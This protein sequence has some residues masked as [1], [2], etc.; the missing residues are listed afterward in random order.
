MI[1]PLRPRYAAALLAAELVVVIVLVACAT[2]AQATT[3][4]DGSHSN[5]TGPGTCSH[6]GGI[7]SGGA[8]S[9]AVDKDCTDFATQQDA[10]AYF[11]GLGGSATNNVD[12]LDADHDGIAC[13]DNP[14][15]GGLP[16]PPQ[17]PPLPPDCG[18][19]LVSGL[20][21]G[22]TVHYGSTVELTAT[23]SGPSDNVSLIISPASAYFG[24]GPLSVVGSRVLATISSAG[25]DGMSYTWSSTQIP[26]S[27]PPLTTTP[28]Q[29]VW[30]MQ[31]TMRTCGPYSRV[32]HFTISA[33]ARCAVTAHLDP[34]M[35][36]VRFCPVTNRVSLALSRSRA[37]GSTIRKKVVAVASGQLAT[38][39]MHTS[40]RAR[41]VRVS[42]ISPTTGATRLLGTASI[43]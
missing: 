12:N 16:Q 4:A 9:G 36:E 38:V 35:V 7:A 37:A 13:E 34:P 1:R 24:T 29:Y 39:R 27:D 32:Q 3:C 41:W 14:S 30:Q 5:S 10:Q 22:A 42:Y 11:V 43:R 23:G 17:P 6:H 31:D 28:G 20:A 26:N 15:G 33:P 25:P 18:P 21:A 40:R 2:G 19:L 8:S